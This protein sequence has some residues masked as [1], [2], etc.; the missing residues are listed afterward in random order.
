MYFSE[1]EYNNN[2]LNKWNSIIGKRSAKSLLPKIY[3]ENCIIN[4]KKEVSP[5]NTKIS[6]Y[7]I[8][9]SDVLKRRTNAS[10]PSIKNKIY[11]K[12]IIYQNF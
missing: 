5:Y 10:N 7:D 1:I 11:L 4:C 2:M 3:I 12:F 9:S 8:D 6:A